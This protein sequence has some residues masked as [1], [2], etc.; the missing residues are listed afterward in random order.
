M[1][2]LCLFSAYPGNSGALVHLIRSFSP[3]LLNSGALVHLVDVFGPHLLHSEA[4]WNKL[5]VINRTQLLL[6]G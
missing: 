2:L 4:H 1:P 3:R 6:R 5:Y